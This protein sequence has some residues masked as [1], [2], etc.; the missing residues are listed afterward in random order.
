MSKLPLVSFFFGL[1]LL[2][3]LVQTEATQ[4]LYSSF[5]FSEPYILLLLTHGSWVLLWPIQLL[6]LDFA[7]EKHSVGS[8]Y[9]KELQKVYDISE[10]I[11]NHD[12]GEPTDTSQIT[13]T[14]YTHLTTRYFLFRTMVAR[15][16]MKR[17]FKTTVIITTASITWY[18]AMIYS[19]SNDITAIYNCSAFF[20][21]LFAVPVLGE[22]FSWLRV[23]S[24][25]M[26]IGGVFMVVYS[27]ASDSE[28]S[29][30]PHALFGNILILVGSVLYGYYDVYYKKHLCAPEP[31]VHELSPLDQ[32]KYSNFVCSLIGAS[33]VPLLGGLILFLQVSGLKK[34]SL[35]YPL[36]VWAYV[37]LSVAGNLC[38][39]SSMLILYSLT[40]PVLGAVS[41]LTTIFLVGVFEWLF[42]GVSLGFYQVLGD[43]VVVSGFC[44][45]I[46]SYRGEVV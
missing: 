36:Q 15:H 5:H 27:G 43:L 37:I 14:E 34:A 32:S 22:R 20:A 13:E 9:R 39:S 12:H 18:V 11:Y 30:K 10:I 44:L 21:Y 3:F 26:A 38:Y 4:Y 33:S 24:V 16:V 25:V 23:S 28:E 31:H 42:F 2:A 40:S 17:A 35:D 41:S 19:F 29:T 8:S 1:S 45:L 6:L 7:D 46:Y